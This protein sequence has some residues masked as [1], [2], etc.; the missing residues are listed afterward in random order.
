MKFIFSTHLKR[1]P[2]AKQN[3]KTKKEIRERNPKNFHENP[4]AYRKTI[5][6][7][8]ST[9]RPVFTH[10]LFSQNYMAGIPPK[11]PTA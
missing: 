1:N 9:N 2:M 3:K 11:G 4:K 8:T 6:I 10:R 5:E 7:K